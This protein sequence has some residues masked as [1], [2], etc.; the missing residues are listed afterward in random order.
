MA[1]A[2][3]DCLGLDGLDESHW[4][5]PGGTVAWATDN[6]AVHGYDDGT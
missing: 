2:S 1:G 5:V 3:A 4:A 6:G